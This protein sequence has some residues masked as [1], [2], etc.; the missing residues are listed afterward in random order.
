MN[1]FFNNEPTILKLI[2]RI[3]IYISYIIH[4]EK[5]L[6]I[7]KLDI[8]MW[9]HDLPHSR[10]VH[11]QLH[12]W[13]GVTIYHTRVEYTNN[14]TI[15]VVS[16]STTLEV[17]AITL[18]RSKCLIIRLDFRNCT[19]LECGRSWHHIGGVMVRVL[20]SSLLDRWVIGGVMVKVLASS[21]VD[22]DTTSVV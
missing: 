13:C 14:Y 10:R 15:D 17:Q 11:K 1:N 21:V 2:V 16:L 3:R 22:R 9:S 6:L 18:K 5:T 12:H 7:W 19:R 4:L 8:P 20:A